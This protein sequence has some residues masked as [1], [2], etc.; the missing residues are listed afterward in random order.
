MIFY[1]NGPRTRREEEIGWKKFSIKTPL[2]I[3][4]QLLLYSLSVFARHLNIIFSRFSH[5][6]FFFFDYIRFFGTYVRVSNTI[7]FAS[8]HVHRT[9][10]CTYIITRVDGNSCRLLE[11]IILF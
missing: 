9:I 2:K 4:L 5:Y 8:I 1:F 3:R 7:L 6:Y 11:K 10:M